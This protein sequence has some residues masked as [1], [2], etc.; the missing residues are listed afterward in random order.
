MAALRGQGLLLGEIADQ[1][2]ISR[3]RVR[4]ILKRRGGPDAGDVAA[5]RRRRVE[6][7]AEARIDEL[8]GRWRAGEDPRTVADER[9]LQAAACRRTIER[10]ATDVDRRARRASMAGSGRTPTYSR[11][12]V[13][14]G[15]IPSVAT[16]ETYAA[17]RDDLPSAATVRIRLGRWS[18]IT[19]RLATG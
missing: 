10:F 7:L 8:L 4:Q 6:K 18:A 11:A 3:E 5:A 12:V 2:R 16:Y 1:F 15:G 13:E 9:G 17:G 14:L 19:A